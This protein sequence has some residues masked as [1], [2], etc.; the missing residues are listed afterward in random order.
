M[1]S[2]LYNSKSFTKLIDHYYNNTNNIKK[3]IDK[4][5]KQAFSTFKTHI[6]Q[7][8]DY[9][10]T[11]KL[12]ETIDNQIKNYVVILC[13]REILDKLYSLYMYVYYFDVKQKDKS[14][15]YISVDFEFYKNN[16][17]LMQINFE[18]DDNKNYIW[19]TN[20][21]NFTKQQV[22]IFVDIILTNNKIYKILHGSESNDLPYLFNNILIDNQK[23][24]NFTRRL[25]DTVYLCQYGIY[26]SDNKKC[27][28]YNALLFFSVIDQ[29]KYEEL[30]NINK[31]MGPIQHIK[32][33]INN[34]KDIQIY[35][36]LYDVLYLRS[37]VH[38]SYKYMT[39]N[40]PELLKTYK[41]IPAITR[42]V[43]LERKHISN[44]IN[45]IKQTVDT[46][47]LK[48]GMINKYKELCNNITQ[49]SEINLEYIY[50]VGYMTKY[51]SY[52][53]KYVIYYAVCKKDGL[54]CDI[55]IDH[56]LKILEV[57]RGK[58]II[59]LIKYIEEYIYFIK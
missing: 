16:I 46:Y 39:L 37:L 7:I 49:N 30:E 45:S 24:V 47:N 28:L 48:S 15:S 3:I 51:L 38:N 57:Y 9:Y 44:I 40:H 1:E 55:N 56:I 36:A 18:S 26:K 31:K 34:L 10:S 4:N 6:L 23:I 35:Y 54:N 14:M 2:S 41:Y 29:Q 21:S 53:V 32:W 19:L 17:A 12:K 58:K 33:N 25:I 50:S 27:S 8:V 5:D 59:E 43:I 13:N 11:L 42:F 22:D 52:L 20:P